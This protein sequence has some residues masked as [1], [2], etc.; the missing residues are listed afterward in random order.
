MADRVINL[1][2]LIIINIL[3]LIIINILRLITQALL[4]F[5]NLIQTWFTQNKKE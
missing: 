2:I 1:N 4:H 3:R 5:H